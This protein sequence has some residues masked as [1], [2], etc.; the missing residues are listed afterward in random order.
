MGDSLH[1]LGD[2]LKVAP[3]DSM[4]DPAL[5]TQLPPADFHV[6]NFAWLALGVVIVAVGIGIAMIA[7][8]YVPLE[9]L[10]PPKWRGWKWD[11]KE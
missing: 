5:F 3:A 2:S 10:R 8:G 11:G 6:A 9:A 4:P 1:W 7:S